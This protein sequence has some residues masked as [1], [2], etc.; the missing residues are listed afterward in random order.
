MPRT[1]YL[2]S[3]KVVQPVSL[4]LPISDHSRLFTLPFM[5]SFFSTYHYGFRL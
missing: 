5:L 1:N 3:T 2:L 4:P